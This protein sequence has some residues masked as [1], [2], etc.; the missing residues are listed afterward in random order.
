[1]LQPVEDTLT[2]VH[3]NEPQPSA[4]TDKE[5]YHIVIGMFVESENAYK[6]KNKAVTQGFDARIVHGLK[7]NRVIIPFAKDVQPVK[8]QLEAI[9]STLEPN[10]WVWESRNR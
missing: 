3:T 9:R 4:Q 8:T 1:M 6:M 5:L 2:D 7:Y 10:A